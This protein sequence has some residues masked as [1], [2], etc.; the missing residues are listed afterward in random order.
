MSPPRP[1]TQMQAA[2]KGVPYQR[3]QTRAAVR[4][5]RSQKWWTWR[6]PSQDR[7]ADEMALIGKNRK[8]V[9]GGRK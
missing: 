6:S 1:G 8:S 3:R 5:F 2:L 9:N 7:Q 4:P